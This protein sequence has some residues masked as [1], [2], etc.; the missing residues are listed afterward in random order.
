VLE[1][2]CGNVHRL[3]LGGV[4]LGEGALESSA[5]ALLQRYGSGVS[6]WVLSDE[7]TEA[8]AGERWKEAIRA[9]SISS[10]ILPGDPPPLPKLE[11]AEALTAEVRALA[12][13]LLVGVGSGVLSDLV[14]KVSL[15][16]GIPSWCIAT[17]ASV[18][19]YTS[20]RSAIRVAGYHR[21]LPARAS[22]VIVCDLE[23]LVRAPRR[24]F[25]AGLGDLLAKYLASVDWRLAQR[26]AGETYC[27]VVGGF[28][29]GSA[30]R[31]LDAGRVW[32]GDPEAAL[33]AL[34]EAGL[35]SGFAMQAFGSSRP[36]ASA[37]HTVAH[38]WETV[39][40]AKE[41]ELHGILVGA[42]TKLLLPGYAAW[43]GPSGGLARLEEPDIEQRLLD[44]GREPPWEVTL[45]EGMAPYRQMIAD[46]Q[47][48]KTLDLSILR[49]RL[50]AFV[51]EK[52]HILA[53]AEPLLAELAKAVETL[54]GLG[55]PFSLEKLRIAEPRRLLPVRN[56]RLLRDRYTA[57]DLAHELGRD[58]ELF[59][60]IAAGA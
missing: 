14:K 4:I 33:S 17:A 32:G 36:A 20:A 18:D 13:D 59:A 30:R 6:L 16:A 53:F 49:R 24:L 5:R 52:E 19:A 9:A 43:L 12:P 29:L 7:R 25:L 54:D 39:A 57:F 50:Q 11:L 23:V 26:V 42:A 51:R 56:V 21:A 41:H 35:V 58:A 1:C 2:P 46:E 38:F 31:A 45:E 28:A 15:D 48:G 34:A 55:F 8:A 40:D 10:R 47:Q 27:E 3:S 44:L 22:E 37:E 60:A